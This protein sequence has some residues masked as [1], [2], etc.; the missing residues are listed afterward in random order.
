LIGSHDNRTEMLT[1]MHALSYG[2][3]LESHG[4]LALLNGMLIDI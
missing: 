3:E 4:Y 1:Y 2:T